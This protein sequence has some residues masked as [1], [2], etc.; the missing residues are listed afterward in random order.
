M[1]VGVIGIGRNYELSLGYKIA[2]DAFRAH[3]ERNAPQRL[4]VNNRS[5]AALDSLFQ[6][7]IKEVLEHRLGDPRVEE[8][9]SYS[10]RRATRS[11]EEIVQRTV[12]RA[13]HPEI[14]EQ[15]AVV[16]ICL[17]AGISTARITPALAQHPDFRKALYHYN[18]PEI[19]KLAPYFRNY[20]GM[21]LMVTN[22][23][24][25]LSMDF[26]EHSGLDP[27]QIVGIHP[28]T[29]RLRD[30]TGLC[31]YLQQQGLHV[32]AIEN[33]EAIYVL[34]DHGGPHM[35]IPLSSARILGR[36]SLAFDVNK[37]KRGIRG[38]VAELA[39]ET[40]RHRKSTSHEISSLVNRMMR[41]IVL[42]DREEYVVAVYAEHVGKEKKVYSG[43]PVV[44]VKKRARPLPLDAFLQP[45]EKAEYL[46][47]LE[48]MYQAGLSKQADSQLL[49]EI[50]KLR[51]RPSLAS[52]PSIPNPAAIKALFRPPLFLPG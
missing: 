39:N 33:M 40:L 12:V 17:E 5:S 2:Q 22:P 15:S 49:F 36:P 14:A 42:D 24:G 18:A 30:F 25:W 32:D 19:R 47:C 35:T 44:F 27:C 50:E 51:H 52:S 20:G 41:S 23:P 38:Y 4:L 34:G 9:F 11:V 3:V 16:V 29:H 37:V 10:R 7:G 6:H 8:R 13:T 1:N 45:S 21:V 31:R 28:E 48:K 46:V 26:L 43:E